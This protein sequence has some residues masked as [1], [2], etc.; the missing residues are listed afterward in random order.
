MYETCKLVVKRHNY[1]YIRVMCYTTYILVVY[2]F[3]CEYPHTGTTRRE[4]LLSALTSRT[5]DANISLLVIL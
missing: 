3:W 5:S 4:Q 2:F 1:F